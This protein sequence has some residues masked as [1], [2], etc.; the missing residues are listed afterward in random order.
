MSAVGVEKTRSWE[1][2]QQSQ[3]S[4]WERW[5]RELPVDELREELAR[6]AQHIRQ[7]IESTFDSDLTQARILEVGAA[8]RPVVHFLPGSQRACVDPLMPRCR[9]LRKDLFGSFGSGAEHF[10]AVAESLPFAD[11][12][13][14]LCIFLNAVDVCFD[15][16]KAVAELARVL[17]HRGRLVISAN[18]YSPLARALRIAACVTGLCHDSPAYPRVFTRR[19]FR[20]LV[21][22]RFDVAG[23]TA[24][25]SVTRLP[26][27]CDRTTLLARKRS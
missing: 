9:E 25:P 23:S 21:E 24:E 11:R 13:F 8:L 3:L 5:G 19:S 15:S 14:D 12:S 6:R 10:A 4:Y 22:T 2:G 16:Q 1:H 20:A 17:D 26:Y 7:L 27:R 18:T